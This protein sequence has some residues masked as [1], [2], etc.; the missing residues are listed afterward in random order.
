MGTWK[1]VKLPE[2]RKTVGCK[3]VLEVKTDSEGRLQ[4]RKARLVAK[5]YSQLDGIDYEETF[6]PVARL[7]SVRLI[8]SFAHKH[9]WVLISLDA[10]SAYLNGY[11]DEE[12]YMDQPPGFEDGTDSV[13]LLIRS[14]Y[15]LK[16]AGRAWF[17][18][19]QAKLLEGGYKELQTEPC[20]FHLSGANGQ[21]TAILTLYV[22]DFV[23]AAKDQSTAEKIKADLNRWFSMTDNG[24]L[25]YILGLKVEQNAAGTQHLSQ[26]AYI[27]NLAQ[28]FPSATNRKVM[29]PVRHQGPPG[30]HEGEPLPP[31]ALTRFAKLTGKLLWVSLGTRID[32]A[33]IVGHLARFISCATTAHNEAALRVVRY[34]EETKTHGLT[35]RSA[36]HAVLQGFADSDHS[37]DSEERRSTSGYVFQHY[38]NT[39][40][41]HSKLQST[42]SASTVE[43][44]YVALAT[45]TSEALFLRHIMEELNYHDPD[46]RG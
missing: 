46:S 27:V 44:E 20:I 38:G 16:Q 15:G 21:V 28:E 10:K 31:P 26:T 40:S 29:S 45:A 22:D 25:E 12:I 5:G 37:G 9:R 6:A 4:K 13:C 2:G 14:L 33:Y 18:V 7:V 24:Q 39:I 30:K 43:S 17:L 34:L 8:I 32:I 1:L 11:L 19:L 3:W 23:I 42:T 35:F 41:W 36:D